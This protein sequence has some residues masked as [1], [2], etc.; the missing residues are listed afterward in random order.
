MIKISPKMSILNSCPVSSKGKV[1]ISS[2]SAIE[3]PKIYISLFTRK[4]IVKSNDALSVFCLI[5]KKSPSS[6]CSSKQELPNG[7]RERERERKCN[8]FSGK[9]NES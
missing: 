7:A 1:P 5:E 9:H 3:D 2:L 6:S 8:L 4:L